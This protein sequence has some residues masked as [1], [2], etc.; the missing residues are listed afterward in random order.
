[1]VST[2]WSAVSPGWASSR[3]ASGR[4]I[5]LRGDDVPVMPETQAICHALDVDPLALIGSGAMLICTPDPRALLR[6]LADA[7]I[8]AAEVG[9]ITDRERLLVRRGRTSPLTPPDRDEIY[10]I[11]EGSPDAV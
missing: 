6:A 10:R 5:V 9:V 3:V 11:L 2:T 1:M 4:G 8:P 7:G